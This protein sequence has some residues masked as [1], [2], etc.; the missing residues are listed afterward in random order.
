MRTIRNMIGYARHR[1]HSDVGRAC[2]GQLMIVCVCRRISDR[3]IAA[4]AREGCASFEEMQAELGVAQVCGRCRDCARSVFEASAVAAPA[5]AAG[6]Q[7]V[8]WQPPAIGMAA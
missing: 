6:W 4:V 1:R 7:P 3:Q 5:T 8:V 2:R